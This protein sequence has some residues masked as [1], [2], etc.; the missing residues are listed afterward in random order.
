MADNLNQETPELKSS[1][2]EKEGSNSSTD[3]RKFLSTAATLVTG[4][5][6]GVAANPHQA[7]AKSDTDPTDFPLDTLV[8]DMLHPTSAALLTDT[9]ANLTKGDLFA[10][11]QYHARQQPYQDPPSNLVLQDVISLE[12]AF[13][14]HLQGANGVKETEFNR[15]VRDNVSACCCCTP[16]CCTAAAMPNNPI[17]RLP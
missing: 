4:L 14:H 12:D 13:D 7:F 2:Q 1:S 6:V 5:A 8:K 3:R 10:L 16:C 17:T 11:R 9:A 15:G